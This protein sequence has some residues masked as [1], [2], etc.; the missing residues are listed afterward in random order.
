MTSTKRWLAGAGATE[1]LLLG[2][3]PAL[4]QDADSS[5]TD[6]AT[7]QSS[8]ATPE[9]DAPAGDRDG[10]DRHAGGDAAQTSPQA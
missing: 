8:E 3:V 10:G 4:A 2:T 7:E 5:A 1:V 9:G 6:Q